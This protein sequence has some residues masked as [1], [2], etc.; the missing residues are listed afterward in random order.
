[1][2]HFK[3]HHLH[4]V[5]QDL[6]AMIA[7]WTAAL[8]GQLVERRRFGSA[9]GATL[10]VDGIRVNL[11]L[12]KKGEVLCARGE[13]VIVGFDHIGLEVEDLNSAICR[14][15]EHGCRVASNPVV[16]GK[17]QTVFMRGPENILLELMAL[18]D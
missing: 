17:R 2:I 4:L 9:E 15:V 5:C 14:L 8:G 11:R 12:S 1:M 18:D 7:F 10:E 16:N 6:E 3:F 13:D